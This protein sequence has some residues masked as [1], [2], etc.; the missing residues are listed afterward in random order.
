M[1]EVFGKDT[2]AMLES[3]RSAPATEAKKSAPTIF[4]KTA[5]LTTA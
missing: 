4:P 1:E 3:P 2:G 5:S